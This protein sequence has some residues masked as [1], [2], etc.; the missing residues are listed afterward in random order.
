MKVKRKR[1]KRKVSREAKVYQIRTEN[2]I[3]YEHRC[4]RCGKVI[5]RTINGLEGCKSQVPCTKCGRLITV[6]Y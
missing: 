4:P 1:R 6:A 5:S 2:G 3:E